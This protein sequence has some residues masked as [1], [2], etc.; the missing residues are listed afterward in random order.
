MGGAGGIDHYADGAR[1]L[2]IREGGRQVDELLVWIIPHID[3]RSFAG[4]A[5][6]G[7]DDLVV[8]EAPGHAEHLDAGDAGTV[9]GPGDCGTGQLVLQDGSSGLEID[10]LLAR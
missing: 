2:R 8:G 7:V 6:D 9:F 4:D 3:R 1:A 10:E 5:G